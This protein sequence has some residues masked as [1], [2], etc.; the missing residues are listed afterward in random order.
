MKRIILLLSVLASLTL[1]SNSVKAVQSPTNGGRSI[2][3]SLPVKWEV[4]HVGID[5]KFIFKKKINHRDSKEVT[6]TFALGRGKAQKKE[7]ETITV[8]APPGD[9]YLITTSTGT[10]SLVRI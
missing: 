7:Y 6:D 9:Y 4:V 3:D 2:H 8:Y 1:T 5:G 10:V